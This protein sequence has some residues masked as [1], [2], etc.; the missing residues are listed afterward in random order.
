[1]YLLFSLLISPAWFAEK[2][3]IDSEAEH[4]CAVHSPPR[5]RRVV[6]DKVSRGMETVLYCTVLYCTVL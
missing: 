4:Y 2:L 5:R 6:R 3:K 1:M